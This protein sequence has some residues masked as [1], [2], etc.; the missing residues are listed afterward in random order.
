[1]KTVFKGDYYETNIV[2]ECNNCR[3]VESDPEWTFIKVDKQTLDKIHEIKLE[4]NKIVFRNPEFY[5]DCKKF[6]KYKDTFEEVIKVK[7]NNFNFDFLT[8]KVFFFKILMERIQIGKSSYGPVLK[9]IEVSQDKNDI[10]T[11]DFL[12][13]PG[14]TDSDEELQ[15]HFEMYN[16]IDLKNNKINKINKI[17]KSKKKKSHGKQNNP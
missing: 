17:N 10:V 7:T 15:D 2:L 12:E 13:E 8:S 4:I 16:K 14:I 3:I 9:L 11:T 1:M 6:V 5:C